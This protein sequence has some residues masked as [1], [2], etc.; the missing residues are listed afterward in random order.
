MRRTVRGGMGEARAVTRAAG[1]KCGCGARRRASPFL[2]GGSEVQRQGEFPSYSPLS[3]AATVPPPRGGLGATAKRAGKTPRPLSSIC[4][5]RR[6]AK[7]RCV[8][9]RCGKG[10]ALAL[11]GR[12]CES[13]GAM[14]GNLDHF[15][16]EHWTRRT[17]LSPAAGFRGE[18]V[19]SH[20]GKRRRDFSWVREGLSDTHRAGDRN[21]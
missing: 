21:R 3:P 2:H 10:F 7:T 20:F 13:C 1:E 5:C 14:R 15:R 11:A 17:G 6:H 16:G 9:A 8:P 19:Q 18:R 12:F 4:H